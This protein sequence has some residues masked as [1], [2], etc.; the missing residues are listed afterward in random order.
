MRAQKRERVGR[1]TVV[2]S[3]NHDT[4]QLSLESIPR[5]SEQ[6]AIQPGVLNLEQRERKSSVVKTNNFREKTQDSS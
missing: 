1:S 6:F 2:S 3:S 5:V 4:K